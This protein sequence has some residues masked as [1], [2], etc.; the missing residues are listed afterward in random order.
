MPEKQNTKPVTRV[1]DVEQNVCRIERVG[2]PC[3]FVLF[4]ASG[5]LAAR[6]VLPALYTLFLRRLLPERFLIVGAARTPYSDESFREKT[7]EALKAEAV[8]LAI[9]DWEKFARHLFYVEV[10]YGSDASI[11]A[12]RSRL[13]GLE[14]RYGTTSKRIFYLALPPALYQDVAE[15]LGRAGMSR[16]G[17]TPS[18]LIIEKPFGESLETSRALTRSIHQ[19]FDEPQIY[20]ID[21]YLGKET[22][23]NILMFRFSNAIFEPIWNRQYVDHVQITAS[24][25]IGVEHRAGYYDQAGVIRDMFQNHMLQLLALT[26]MEPPSRFA[27]E[28]VRDER[29]KVFRSVRPFDARKLK[30]HWVTGQYGRGR[31]NGEDVAAY[32]EERNV[33]SSS[34]TPTYAAGIFH[35]DN[36]RWNGVPFYLRSGKRLARGV[37]E[38]AIQ[39]RAAPHRMFDTVLPEAAGPNV[40]VFRVKPGEGIMQ[41]FYTKVPGSRLCLQQVQMVF[42]Y[43]AVQGAPLDGYQRVLLDCMTGDR[44][45]FVRQDGVEL[46]WELLDPVIAGL[47]EGPQ[48]EVYTAGEQG[49]PGA[50]ELLG[51]SGR[52][53]RNLTRD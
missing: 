30:G 43:Q 22:V 38:I 36:W 8:S 35:I 12:L 50:E 33:P 5:D 42:S 46:A 10:D 39:F 17:D 29:S 24:E 45:L 7:G 2:E 19:Y 4:G 34:V 26:A 40:L 32:R 27:A 37:T 31:V 25:S 52:S 41:S 11:K 1:M 53:W 13:S 49:P 28:A 3:V 44:M 14:D 20:R 16:A 6:K 48:P 15:S 18:S 47:T 21:H 51:Q 23:Q 9:E